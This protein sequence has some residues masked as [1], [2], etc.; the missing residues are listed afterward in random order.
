MEIID[1][2]KWQGQIDW[3]KVK[4]Q[5][6][7]IKGVYIK[8]TEGIGYVD[9]FMSKNATAA[10]K[11]GFSIGFYHFASLNKQ[12]VVSDAI[13][14]A[15]AF[16]K[17]ISQFHCQLPPVLDL[18]TNAAKLSPAK[19]LEW[20]KAFF[21]EL[22]RNGINDF[23]LYSYTPF[24]N[25]NLP[26]GHNLGGVKLWIAAYAPKAI[27]PNGWNGYWLWQYSSKGK[28]QGIKGNVDLNKY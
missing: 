24:L 12:D 6:P 25:A 15:K 13:T 9:P 8:A 4:T 20:I 23:V 1:V 17:A 28:V 18:E 26:K 21:Q 7:A 22:Q 2:S 10:L 11:S 3:P 19:C 27:I 14:E 5:N 16:L